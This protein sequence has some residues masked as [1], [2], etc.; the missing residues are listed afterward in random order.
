MG[1][2]GSKTS[3][4]IP[5]RHYPRA[6]DMEMSLRIIAGR[7][8][9][10][11][12]SFGKFMAQVQGWDTA[13]DIGAHVGSW[14]LGLSKNFANVISFEPHPLNR[15]YLETNLARA[16]VDNVTVLPVALVDRPRL[17]QIFRISAAGTTRNSGMPHLIDG[18]DAAGSNPVVTC[19][20]LDDQLAGYMRTGQRI[21]AI[22]IDVEGMELPVLRGGE[23]A[24]REFKPA[25]LLE[26]NGRSARYDITHE[27]IYDHMSDMGY[28]VASRSRNDYVFTASGP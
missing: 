1:T 9:F 6:P 16:A 24:I 23:N 13:V 20:C 5:L 28:S 22:K 15:S 27:E 18:N 10:E 8:I 26:I 11:R 12:R 3:P 21:D 25:I 17:S 7:G 14:T 2:I 19:S 4:H